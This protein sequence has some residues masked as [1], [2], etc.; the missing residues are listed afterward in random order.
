MQVGSASAGD[1]QTVTAPV[2]QPSEFSLFLELP[3]ERPSLYMVLYSDSQPR[4]CKFALGFC[5]ST[6]QAAGLVCAAPP[7]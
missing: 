1:I 3:Q 4:R 6:G 2:G 7:R 5:V